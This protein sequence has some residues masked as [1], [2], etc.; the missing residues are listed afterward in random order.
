VTAA[1]DV[2]AGRP[3]TLLEAVASGLRAVDA[4]ER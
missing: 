3:R 2:V 4:I 1:G